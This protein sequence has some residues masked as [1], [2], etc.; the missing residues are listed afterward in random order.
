ML[1]NRH[2]NKDEIDA[3]NKIV[4][5]IQMTKFKDYLN[6]SI[7]TSSTMDKIIEKYKKNIIID[8]IIL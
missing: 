2:G 5:D 1:V 8:G 4:C 6:N 7:R 3:F